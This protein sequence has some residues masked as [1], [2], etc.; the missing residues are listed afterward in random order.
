MLIGTLS[1]SASV[2]HV[3]GIVVFLFAAVG[4]Y[5]FFSSASQA[6]GGSALPLGRALVS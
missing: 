1:G 6:T 5:L 3:G 2:L 4:G